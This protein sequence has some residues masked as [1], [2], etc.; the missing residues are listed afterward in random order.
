MSEITR[1]DL[2]YVCQELNEIRKTLQD[3]AIAINN[4]VEVVTKKAKEG[5]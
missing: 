5:E 1:E 4:L 2:G 3:I